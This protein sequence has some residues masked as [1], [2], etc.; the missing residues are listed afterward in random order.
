MSK[1]LVIASYSAPYGGNFVSSVKK[2]AVEMQKLGHNVFFA[3]PN[4]T[5]DLEWTRKI[6][7]SFSVKYI[8]KP[9]KSLEFN[10][11]HQI[12]QIIKEF[13]IDVVY[14]HFTGYD[15]DCF[16]ACSNK[17]KLVIHMHNP[18]NNSDDCT[19]KKR[20]KSTIKWGIFSKRVKVIACASHLLDYIRKFG[21]DTSD[22]VYVLN[23]IDV[24]RI[25]KSK[26]DNLYPYD[27]NEI[28]ILMHGWDPYRKGVDTAIEA[29]RQVACNAHL[30]I[31][32]VDYK[33]VS[34]FISSRGIQNNIK[35]TL[36]PAVENIMDYL[37]GADI[38]ISP[39]RAEGSPYSLMEAIMAGK[40][41]IGTNLPGLDWQQEIPALW[42]IDV[43]DVAALAKDIDE[44]GKM[45][46]HVLKNRISIAKN[47]IEQ[48]H[49]T[50]SWASDVTDYFSKKVVC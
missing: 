7:K 29:I 47:I 5:K 34:D 19:W 24:D 25:A 39:S 15:M 28:S 18:I 26:A 40:P 4:D 36:L 2:F 49:S 44:I 31:T 35:V 45:D 9:Y 3:F 21:F 38:F 10:L 12:K 23:G 41:S 50:D 8:E 17:T 32:Y 1:I 22:S 33:V 42:T 43:N 16:F 37:T 14:S 30:Y 46:E 13:N 27:P 11:V 48:K 6:E 20:F